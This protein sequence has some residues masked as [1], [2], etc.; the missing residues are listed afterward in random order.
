V[1]VGYALTWQDGLAHIR[2]TCG[3]GNALN[4]RSLE[5]I[6]AALDAA[7]AGGARGVV[8]TGYDRFFS[9]GLDLVT[10]YELAPPALDDFVRLFDRVMLQVFVHPRPVVAAVNGHAVAGGLILAL[11]CDAR[12]GVEA[13]VRLGLNEVRLGLPFPASALEI[14]RAALPP[15][16][17]AEVLYGGEL[18]VPAEA[19]RRGLV[20]RLA[21]GGVATEAAALCA[22]L[23]EAPS[24]AFAAIKAGLRDPARRRAEASLDALRRAFVEAWFGPEGRARIGATRARLQTPR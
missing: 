12:V 18:Y 2:L 15:A 16:T 11:A 4:H 3:K 9:T 5:A 24:G 10:L 7:A 20:D 1:A 14:A 23:A 6:A 17:L 21:G 19:A 22:R 8:L 13:D